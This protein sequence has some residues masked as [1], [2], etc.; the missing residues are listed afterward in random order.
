MNPLG[1]QAMI[2]GM[3]LNSMPQMTPQQMQLLL[4]NAGRLQGPMVARPP[5]TTFIDQSKAY[6]EGQ[7]Q[8]GDHLFDEGQF[9]SDNDMARER[10]FVDQFTQQRL[11]Q[12]FNERMDAYDAQNTVNE[13]KGGLPIQSTRGRN[14]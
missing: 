14:L 7:L 2:P 1:M 13:L 9:G 11:D 4:V 10:A 5:A 3:T 8:P 6:N 12:M